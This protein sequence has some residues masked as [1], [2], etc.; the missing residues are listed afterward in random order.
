MEHPLIRIRRLTEASGNETRVL[1]SAPSTSSHSKPAAVELARRAVPFCRSAAVCLL[2]L[3]IWRLRTTF[4]S[5]RFSHS[6]EPQALQDWKGE[7]TA[8]TLPEGRILAIFQINSNDCIDEKIADRQITF[9]KCGF[10]SSPGETSWINATFVY[11][12]D[13]AVHAIC[14]HAN[15][16]DGSVE[17]SLLR[18]YYDT[19]SVDLLVQKLHQASWDGLVYAAAAEPEGLYVWAKGIVNVHNRNLH[20]QVKCLVDGVETTPLMLS[21]EIALCPIAQ[22]NVIRSACGCL[23][24][25]VTLTVRGAPLPS[26]ASVCR[27]NSAL[28]ST[29]LVSGEPPQAANHS[30]ASRRIGFVLPNG[31]FHTSTS[32]GDQPMKQY[33]LCS[34]TMVLDSAKFMGEWL[35]Y[36]GFLGVEHFFVYDNGSE[37]GLRES[38]KEAQGTGHTRGFEISATIHSWPWIKSQEG[39]FSHCA[40]QAKKLCT[41]VIF[42]DVDEFV[43]PAQMVKEIE[44]QKLTAAGSQYAFLLP[45]FVKRMAKKKHTAAAMATGGN[46]SCQQVGVSQ[47][48][49][50]T[51]PD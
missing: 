47:S 50:V 33:Y 44:S 30:H 11:F 36:H 4:F 13:H 10:I 25:P 21:Q 31:Y 48:P 22:A 28:D 12:A 15:G 39:C 3:I 49:Q 32:S 35:L 51:N 17:P 26:V 1:N 9:A 43:F 5:H 6:Q 23:N 27:P 46:D 41:W 19:H 20:G 42:I 18:I 16:T 29:S 14:P 40:L 2:T 37:D 34:C 24:T 45:K 7:L 8:I 38:I